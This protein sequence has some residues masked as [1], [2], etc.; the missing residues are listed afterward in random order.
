M[1]PIFGSD[2]QRGFLL[3]PDNPDWS[4]VSFALFFCLNPIWKICEATL[5][6]GSPKEF[7]GCGI[8][9]SSN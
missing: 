7:L 1:G 6:M 3:G 5:G 8:P 2:W 9:A 4:H